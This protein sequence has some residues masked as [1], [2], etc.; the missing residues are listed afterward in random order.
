MST[1]WKR[2]HA[3]FGVHYGSTV[4]SGE[5]V[6]MVVGDAGWDDCGSERARREIEALTSVVSRLVRAF[7]NQGTLS[8]TELD[9]ILGPDVQRVDP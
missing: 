6:E 5:A 3:V 8:P 2:S 7:E 1:R 9:T 4:D